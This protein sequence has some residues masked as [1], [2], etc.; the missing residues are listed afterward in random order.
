LYWIFLAEI[1]AKISVKI[2]AKIP[3][4]IPAK[5]PVE[6]SP[7]FDRSGRLAWAQDAYEIGTTV[8]TLD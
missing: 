4:K 2:P 3:V 6:I 7:Q 1:S 8:A 5:I